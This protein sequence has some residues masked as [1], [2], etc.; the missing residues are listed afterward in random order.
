MSDS[1]T[2]SQNHSDEASEEKSGPTKEDQA[3]SFSRLLEQFSGTMEAVLEVLRTVSPHVAD[4]DASGELTFKLPAPSARGMKILEKAFGATNDQKDASN[5]EEDDQPSEEESE[6]SRAFQINTGAISAGEMSKAFIE[7][8]RE[9]PEALQILVK[10]FRQIVAR[11]RREH[12]LH[13][14]L[15]AMTV[16]TL[17]T[18]IAGVATQ[19]F[20]LH[21]GALPSEE[22]EFSLAELAE[23]DD[24]RDARD[25]AISRRVED[26]M[27]GGF[28]AWDNWFNQLLERG[29]GEIADD[30]THLHEAIQRRHLVVHN[31]GRVSRQYKAK[32]SECEEEVGVEL[33]IDRSYLETAI[34]HVTIFGARLIL[35][36]WA[37]W[38]P[39]ERPEAAHAANERVFSY[40]SEERWRPASCIAKTGR[41][42]AVEEQAR[43][44]LQVNAWQ[45]DIKLKGLD[46]VRPEIEAWD[47]SALSPEYAAAKMALLDDYDH[48]FE[49]LPSLYDQRL[50][51]AQ[52]LREWP[53]FKEARQHPR[54]EE[55]EKLLPP[56]DEEMSADSP[57]SPE[58]SESSE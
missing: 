40:L 15:L 54:W 34:D 27:R 13:G 11:P 45:A 4:L 18:A 14:S 36:A 19:H 10:S 37:K 43:L 56:K 12:L 31:A 47:I 41:E 33:P 25:L 29:F 1:D 21:P 48:L 24:L 7:A 58:R 35:I 55:I 16:G 51:K 49:L 38:K 42:L 44:Y 5:S 22:K 6:G 9:D 30:R 28:E 52:H 50:L 17:E 3:P 8:Y 26:L 23:F 57:K 20:I 2:D 39:E 53:L 46:A 32:V